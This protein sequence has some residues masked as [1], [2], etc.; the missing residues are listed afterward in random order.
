MMKDANRAKK[1]LVVGS[2]VMGHS[3][4]QIFA[5]ADLDV[6]LVDVDEKMLHRAM[7][8]IE[9]SLNTMA[10]FGKIPK[11]NISSI[12][13][14]V[15]PST[16]LGKMAGDVDFVIEAVPEVPGI[17]KKVFSQLDEMCAPDT[18]IASNTSGLDIF[19]IAEVR[20]PERL[21]IAH[22]FVPPH[23]I[24]LVE[25]VPGAK[26]LP[27][28]VSFTKQLM[29][30]TGKQP[31]VLKEFVPSFIVNRIQ[32]AMGIAVQ[33][34]LEKGWASPE[35]IDRAVKYSLGIRLPVI[36]VVQTIDFNGLDLVRDILKN[37]GRDSSFFEKKIEQGRLGVK[38]SKGI[39][40]YGGR[41]EAEIVK[42]RDG[43]FLKMIDHLKK[44]NAFEPV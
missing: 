15:H 3:I 24:P 27:E 29:E 12:L 26:T 39:Y 31:I 8:L 37:L 28:V 18:V 16:D 23:I 22:F 36:G 11:K 20:R 5:S 44:I 41:S 25:I 19:S 1:V 21:V 30:R 32:N 34:M 42:K 17:K 14:R 4:A 9:S 43:L 33:E 10:D 6:A 7:G 13:S 35:D 40:D 2:G 38:T